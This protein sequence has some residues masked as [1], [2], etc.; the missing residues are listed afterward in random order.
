[1]SAWARHLTDQELF[2]ELA[3]RNDLNMQKNTSWGTLLYIL[4]DRQNAM[5]SLFVEFDE[6]GRLLEMGV[7]VDTV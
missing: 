4:P 3:R 1:M 7:W 2:E 5:A 6:E